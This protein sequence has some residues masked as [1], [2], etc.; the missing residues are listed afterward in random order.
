M[1]TDKQNTIQTFRH[2]S[3]RKKTILIILVVLLCLILFFVNHTRKQAAA[4]EETLSAM[5]QT[6]FVEK[7]SLVK[8]I[9]ATGTIV[10]I[11][12]KNMSASL[13]GQKIASVAV[14]VG[15]FVS[16][17]DFLLSFDTTKI[18]GNLTNAQN[19]LS[20][21]ET[22]NDLS[23]S[24]AK[25]NYNTQIENAKNALHDAQEYYAAVLD[26]LGVLNAELNNMT[27]E[28]DILAQQQ[29]IAL[30]E[31][32]L[33]PAKEA[34]EAQ[35]KNYEKTLAAAE[36]NLNA[37]LLNLDTTTQQS[38]V[39]LYEEQLANA[40]LYAPLSGVVTAINYE[41]GDTYNGGVIL[42]IQDCSSFDVQAQI[43]EYDISDV[44][45]GQKVLIKTNATGEEEM[46]GTVTFISPTAANAAAGI[47]NSDVTYKVL[48]KINNPSSRLRLDMSASLSIILEEHTNVL[49][50]PYNAIQTKSDGSTVVSIK[51]E[52]GSFTEL[53]VTVIMES[54]YYTEI[55][56][57]SLT[58]GMEVLLIDANSNGIFDL[59]TGN[60][61][62]RGGF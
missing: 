3:G 46:T 53:P 27:A 45:I 26:Y 17:G 39:E 28:A 57:D 33:T 47:S 38:Q 10:S 52:D 5:Q 61:N 48:I 56:S 32:K 40:T 62:G 18:E 9:G 19:S 30:Y 41:A 11:D 23:E 35:Q 12:A 25:R 58:E 31:A 49:T 50:V 59:L 21:A 15:D 60:R 24:D 29:K 37:T 6:D 34:L 36:N 2:K 16:E 22:R 20:K 7:R 42:T 8:S 44:A 54:N 1:H 55:T 51:N 13:T 43:S 4:F 14:S